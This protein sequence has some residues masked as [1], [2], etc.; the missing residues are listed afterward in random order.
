[1]SEQDSKGLENAGRRKANRF[2]DNEGEGH[3]RTDRRGHSLGRGIRLRERAPV[4]VDARLDLRGHSRHGCDHQPGVPAA[5]ESGADPAAHARQQ[6]YKDLGQG[7][8]CAVR[9]RNGRNLRCRA[10]GGTRQGFE[11]AGGSVAAGPGH[12]RPRM[13]PC[14]LVHGRESVLREDGAH[15]D[16]PRTSRDRHGPLRLH[17]PPW[18]CGFL[19][20]DALDAASARVDLGLRSGPNLGGLARDPHGA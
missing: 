8:G 1:M 2:T 14:H 18:L 15:P 19:G 3:R 6:V 20:L 16:G 4:G 5:M 11:R 7:V 17:A 12:L 9:A 10:N 13:D